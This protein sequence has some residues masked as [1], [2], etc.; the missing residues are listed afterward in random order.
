LAAASTASLEE[1]AAQNISPPPPYKWESFC[2]TKGQV[3][4]RL[5]A[6]KRKSRPEAKASWTALSFYNAR[7]S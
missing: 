4:H 1:L 5:K 6:T 2:P 7:M 3:T